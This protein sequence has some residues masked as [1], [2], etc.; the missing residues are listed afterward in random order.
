M[1]DFLFLIPCS[2]DAGPGSLRAELQALCFKQLKLKKSEVRVWLLGEPSVEENHFELIK[3]KGKSKEEKLR[4]AC[5]LLVKEEELPKY[6]VRLDDDDLINPSVFD[7]LAQKEFDI[8]YDRKHFFYD[9]ATDKT[10]AQS[11]DWI[12]NTA[13]HRMELALTRIEAIGGSPGSD[14]KNYLIACDHSRAWHPFYSSCKQVYPKQPIYIRILNPE[15]ITAR[16]EG[17]F[18]ENRYFSYLAKFGKWNAQLPESMTGVKE[19]LIKIR[20]HF[21]GAPLKYKPKKKF[22]KWI[23]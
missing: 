19:E 18:S 12:A 14:D 9:L 5:D 11:R 16:S 23:K 20:E 22:F 15:S 21:F 1:A 7:E 10:S 17:D 4:E 2:P 6:L 8:A 3:C 13:I